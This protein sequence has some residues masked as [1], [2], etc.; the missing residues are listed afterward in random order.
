VAEARGQFG[1]PEEGELLPLE[2][3][4]R[5]LVMRQQTKKTQCVLK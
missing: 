4:A 1:T 2:A 3:V 5:V